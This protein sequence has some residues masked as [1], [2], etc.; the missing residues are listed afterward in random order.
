MYYVY[1]IKNE[2][3]ELYYGFSD[4][5]KIRLE[6]HNAGLVAS[7][8]NHKWRLIYYEAYRSKKDA[9]MREKRLKHYGQSLNYLKQRIKHSLLNKN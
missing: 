5:L 4:D 7:T 9:L 8:K 2:I 3:E 6:K 1:V